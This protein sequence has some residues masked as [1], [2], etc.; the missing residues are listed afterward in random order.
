MS[1]PRDRHIQHQHRASAN[2]FAIA[3]TDT[4]IPQQR[5]SRY[6]L[7]STNLNP[8][9]LHDADGNHQQEGSLSSSSSSSSAIDTTS[10]TSSSSN[11]LLSAPVIASAKSQSAPS[12][13][14]DK[15]YNS[16]LNDMEN[17][18]KQV[19]SMRR[20]L[21]RLQKERDALNNE[22]PFHELTDSELH[23]L[24]ALDSDMEELTKQL[25][26]HEQSHNAADYFMNTGDILYEY[27]DNMISISNGKDRRRKRT[28]P[29][30]TTE[31]MCH[32]HPPTKTSGSESVTG[33]V[34]PRPDG[35]DRSASSSVSSSVSSSASSST[36][37][38][39]PMQNPTGKKNQPSTVIDFFFKP[40]P[41][42][43]RKGNTGNT[44]NT[45][46]HPST[47]Q[48]SSDTD[49][50]SFTS[51]THPQPTKSPSTSPPQ[52][53]TLS[54]PPAHPPAH[55]PPRQ[56]QS[57]QVLLQ[58]YLQRTDP[59]FV[60]DREDVGDLSEIDVCPDC[61]EERVLIHHEAMLLCPN[62]K[63][64]RS[65]P[66]LVDSNRPSYKDGAREG[67]SYYSYKRINHFNEWLA[68]FQAK[69]TT[70]IPDDV[71]HSIYVELKKERI[72]NMANITP[73]KMKEILKRLKLNKYY[74]HIPHITNRINGQPAPVMTRATE[75]KLRSMFK[76]IQGPFLKHC[77]PE[78]KNFL[79][80]SYVLHK[81]CQLLGLDHFLPCFP[82]LKS[83]EKLHLQDVIWEN[84]CR[85]LRWEFIK[86]V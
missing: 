58:Q 10:S 16:K 75:E 85:E 31:T 38:P 84:I 45:E 81:F 27:Y 28:L 15:L 32:G 9:G 69:E 25:K 23:R 37:T 68:Q 53:P 43:M 42:S 22:K 55:P 12:V 2:T 62:P 79:S 36:H 21:N 78:R 51:T 46:A 56:Y 64:A 26:K 54:H 34:P 30:T 20:Q 33:N 77:P 48:A 3:S 35:T 57:R 7:D 17:H 6:V 8:G 18:H 39:D 86:S 29:T 40:P 70:D 24:F 19:V 63:C 59:D 72:H 14:L 73:A 71:Y 83:R 1:H 60:K 66:V 47:N 76:E 65:D 67:T 49:D 61:G 44:G 41:R 11:S 74:E 4:T 52:S 82:L 50:E 13:T 80:Y 5:F